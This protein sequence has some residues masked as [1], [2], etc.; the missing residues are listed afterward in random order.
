MKEI[1]GRH[2]PKRFNEATL[3]H[4][5]ETGSPEWAKWREQGLGGSDIGTI[6]GLNEY[7]SAYALWAER[8]GK[9]DTEPVDNWSVRFGRAFEMP[10]LELWAEQNPDWEIFTT[11]TYCDK[12]YPFL[13]ASP[14]ALAKHRQTGEWLLLEVKTARYSW[15]SL[16]PSYN[17]QV[18][19]YLDIM[20][21]TRGLVIAVA[22]WNWFEQEIIYDEFQAEAQR[23]AAVNFWS[24]IQADKEPDF[25][26]A[27]STYEAIRK[28]HPEID[29]ELSVE[30]PEADQLLLAQQ[31][32]D[33]AQKELN[34]AK[35]R[36]LAVMGKAKSAYSKQGDKQIT[37]AT[38]QVRG[39]GLP[40]LVIKK[41][42]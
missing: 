14:D 6:L 29:L 4:E 18:M 41:G 26:G 8:T 7:K 2:I 24:L 42:R 36:A 37:V 33:S 31:N 23:Q 19:H 3:I 34:L 30:L 11:G 13:Q 12:V 28:Q 35:S 17:A 10:I 40:Y 25:D 1:I 21:I 27:T 38:R 15:D 39:D 22:G 32:Y 20:G 5:A 16:P 9:I